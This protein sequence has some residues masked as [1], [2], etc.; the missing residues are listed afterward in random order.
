MT[1]NIDINEQNYLCNKNQQIPRPQ[2]EL[3]PR[4]VSLYALL[5]TAETPNLSII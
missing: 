1:L 2:K 3:K 5:I 4:N